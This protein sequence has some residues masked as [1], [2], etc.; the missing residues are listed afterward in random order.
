VSSPPIPKGPTKWR[1]DPGQIEV[2]DDAVAEILRHKTPA[3]RVAMALAANRL[4]R[5][6]IEG[7]LRTIH[8]DWTDAQVQAEIARRVLLGSG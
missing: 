7:H 1:L 3:E 8:P 4:V 5:L 6:R 2:V